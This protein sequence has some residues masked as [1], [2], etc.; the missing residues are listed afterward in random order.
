MEEPNLD[1]L[2]WMMRN[3]FIRHQDTGELVI[4]RPNCA[5]LRLWGA[6]NAQMSRD[7]PVRLIIV[8]AR[9]EGVST[10]IEGLLFQMI[11]RYP[12]KLAQV[13]SADTDST[14][15][16][17]TMSKLFHEQ[18][19][20]DLK[21]PTDYSNK[22][23][24]VYSAPHRSKLM[25]QTAGKDVLGR[26]GTAQYFHG[27][28]VA[29]WPNAKEGLGGALQ[30]VHKVA[31]TMVALES[32]GNGVGGEFY[33]RYVRAVD[34]MKF[35]PDDYAGFLPIFLAWHTFPTYTLACK[36]LNLTEEE[37]FLARRYS[38]T[39][40]QLNWR[41]NT[42]KSECGGDEILFKQEYPACWEE[43]FQASGRSVFS[44]SL[45]SRWSSRAEEP[46]TVIFSDGDYYD[47]NRQL[48]CWKIW[49]L[50]QIGHQY[51]MG[52]D[53]MEGKVSDKKNERSEPDYHGIVIYDRTV[54]E[55]AA[56]YHGRIDQEEL[57]LQCLWAAKMYN[58]AWVAPE[59]PLGTPILNVFKRSNYK[60]L[61]NREIHD[62]YWDTDE[63]D[64]LG[65]K[66]TPATRPIMI[67]QFLGLI[68]SDEPKIYSTDIINEMRSFVRDKTGRA[69]HLPGTHDDLIFGLMIALQVH[70]RCPMNPVPYEFATTGGDIERK[71][72]KDLCYSG[73]IDPGIQEEEEDDSIFE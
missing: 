54:N 33:D 22:K 10:L 3:L 4:F 69:V 46:R 42:I 8:K 58:H 27:S 50:P 2:G 44:Q 23:E 63:T 29:F 60:N 19:P 49:R 70:F 53:P 68:R 7:L 28:E 34:Q 30:Q 67:E 71:Q 43:A 57:G 13:V 31:G 21:R 20:S 18:M 64:A 32:T 24:I 65:W 73:A 5:Q 6:I 17:F 9:Q 59:M 25:V 52:I 26:G 41:R 61:Y 66:T 62:E 35:D 45:L 14:N 39:L 38:L 36:D 51:T 12:D 37:D 16:V 55:V 48:H 47:V 40:D 11:N 1:I 72:Q 15:L 56:I